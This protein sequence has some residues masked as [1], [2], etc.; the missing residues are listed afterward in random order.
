MNNKPNFAQL[1][2]WLEGQLSPV[3][4]EQVRAQVAA[5]ENLQA[6]VAWIRTFHQTRADLA[7][8]APPAKVRVDLSRRFAALAAEKRPP[9]LWQRLTAALKFDSQLQPNAA[10][11]RSSSSATERQLVYSAA[12]ADVALTIQALTLAKSCN[13]FGQILPTAAEMESSHSIQLWQDGQERAF[14]VA[15]DVG[16]F[17]FEEMPEGEYELVIRSDR[18]EIV[19]PLRLAV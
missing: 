10:G 18:Y 4:A 3:E 11:V 19:I 8:E 16:E 17:V 12:Y 2:D 6:E 13:V 1:V 5:D 14:V 15:A 9:D 7:W